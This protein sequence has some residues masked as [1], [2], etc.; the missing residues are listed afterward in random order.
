MDAK[1]IADYRRR[2][3]YGPPLDWEEAA[4]LLAHIDDLEDV[5]RDAE[6]LAR[7]ASGLAYEHAKHIEELQA[8][9]GRLRAVVCECAE[10]PNSAASLDLAINAGRLGRALNA[11]QRGDLEDA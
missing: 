11:L 9:R 4:N 10:V 3:M 8:S 6:Q 5:V 2:I 7:D 1:D